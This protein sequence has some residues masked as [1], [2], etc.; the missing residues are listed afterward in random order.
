MQHDLL[1]KARKS[2]AKVQIKNFDHA[3]SVVIPGAS[4]EKLQVC[5]ANDLADHAQTSRVWQSLYG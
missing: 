2:V 1:D 3:R 5:L 4:D